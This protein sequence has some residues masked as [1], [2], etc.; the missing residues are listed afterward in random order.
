MIQNLKLILIL[1]SLV[2]KQTEIS[3]LKPSDFC[4][5]NGWPCMSNHKIHC[6]AVS[7]CSKNKQFCEYYD[8]MSY[9]LG[10]NAIKLNKTYQKNKYE[11]FQ[12]SIPICK[13]N[14]NSICLNSLDCIQTK[15]LI[16]NGKLIRNETKIIDCKC[17]GDCEFKCSR[18]Y[19]ANDLDLCEMIHKLDLANLNLKYCGNTKNYTVVVNRKGISTKLSF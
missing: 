10:K 8:T 9:L 16:L 12:R 19:C 11:N 6:E 18:N 3:S 1:V 14:T 15:E 7:I 5:N 17:Q 13:L 2:L 4:K